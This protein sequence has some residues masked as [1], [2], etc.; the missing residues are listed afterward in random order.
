MNDTYQLFCKYEQA[1]EKLT[2]LHD[3]LEKAK[4]EFTEAKRNILNSERLNDSLCGNG[5]LHNN[6]LFKTKCSEEGT[7]LSINHYDEPV[8]SFSIDS[9]NKQ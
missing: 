8:N 5:V 3:E 7:Y 1:E 2:H 6:K 9:E 4:D